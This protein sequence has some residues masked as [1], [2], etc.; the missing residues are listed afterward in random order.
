L[1]LGEADF[2]IRASFRP[3]WPGNPRS[4]LA[5]IPGATSLCA[6]AMSR[7]RPTRGCSTW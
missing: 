2:R 1:R 5:R 3:F 6:Q 7:A 4:Q